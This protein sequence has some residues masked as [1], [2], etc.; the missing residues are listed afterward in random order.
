M[1][2]VAGFGEGAAV[3]GVGFCVGEYVVACVLGVIVVFEETKVG[4]GVVGVVG[5]EVQDVCGDGDDGEEEEGGECEDGSRF[6]LIDSLSLLGTRASD[7]HSLPL[8]GVCVDVDVHVDVD[9]FGYLET[10][11]F[12]VI[13]SHGGDDNG[14]VCVLGLSIH[15]CSYGFCRRFCSVR[16]DAFV[17][18]FVRS[19]RFFHAGC[20]FGVPTA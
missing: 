6:G 4:I 20:G 16:L 3:V 9:V 17:N 8:V 11:L 7:D 13:F 12:D 1:G 2:C 15:Q 18:Y 5:V 19:H 10:Q 14:N